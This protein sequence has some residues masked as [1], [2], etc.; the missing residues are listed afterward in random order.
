MDR[1]TQE[2]QRVHAEEVPSDSYLVHTEGGGTR[3]V[4]KTK[5]LRLTLSYEKN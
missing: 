3:I 4:H 5:W 2:N 1:S